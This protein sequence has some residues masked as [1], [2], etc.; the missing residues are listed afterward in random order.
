MAS[1]ID[2]VKANVSKF[3]TASLLTTD[4]GDDCEGTGLSDATSPKCIKIYEALKTL[5]LDAA[6]I[7]NHDLAISTSY[8]KTNHS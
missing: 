6:T 8:L 5:N 4:V 3:P 1:Y 7:G 2:H